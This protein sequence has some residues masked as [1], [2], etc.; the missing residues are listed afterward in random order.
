MNDLLDALRAFH[1][2]LVLSVHGLTDDD[3]RRPESSD[4]W[5]I[6]D[7]IAHLGD[8]EL[9]SAV[10]IRAILA[11]DAPAVPVLDQE[12]WVSRV[13]RRDEPVVELLEQLWFHRRMNIRL[14]ERLANEDFTRQGRHY[15]FGLLTIGQIGER[16][17]NHDEKHLEQIERIKRALS[18]ESPVAPSLAGVERVC[19]AAAAAA[20]P[21]EGVRVRE[22]WTSG[23]RRALQV[24][25]D[26][27]ARWP[28]IDHHVPGPEEVYV[29]SGD[30]DDG[31][32]VHGPGTFLHHP[33]GTSHAPRSEAGCVLFVYYPEG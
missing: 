29:V 9:I 4:K 3:M 19:A 23:I 5:S 30:Y 12:R 14:I 11:A 8:L 28:G 18:L 27:G 22:L 31:V 1:S 7:V 32:E 21:G 17:R 24:E 16:L 15:E 13:H 2:R 26:P 20:S 6:A 25:F 10:R 33:A